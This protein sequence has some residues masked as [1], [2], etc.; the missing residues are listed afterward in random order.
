MKAIVQ[1]DYGS[2][3]VLALAEVTQPE[4]KDNHS[5]QVNDCQVQRG[6]A[7]KFLQGFHVFL[8]F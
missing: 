7:A 3:D 4:M 1:N 8:L 5:D 2:P 6:E